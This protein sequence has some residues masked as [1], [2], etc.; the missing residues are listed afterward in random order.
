[1]IVQHSTRL[2][3][4]D[5]WIPRLTVAIYGQL[6]SDGPITSEPPVASDLASGSHLPDY[7]NV[8]RHSPSFG[9]AALLCT[10][11]VGDVS[12]LH[13]LRLMFLLKPSD[14]DWEIPGYPARYTDLSSLP[15][16]DPL[17]DSD[18]VHPKQRWLEQIMEELRFP[19][20]DD[21]PES[22]L[23]F[24]SEVLFTALEA[25]VSR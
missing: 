19:V 14:E 20:H 15:E 10:E 2:L 1:M 17:N 5:T 25:P 7:L 12:P 18:G 11:C 13:L 21:E 23:L 9:L 24:L 3:I 22:T 8:S 6:A 16:L 4:F